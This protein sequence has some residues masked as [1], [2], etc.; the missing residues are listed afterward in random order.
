MVV[1]AAVL[2]IGQRTYSRAQVV[3]ARWEAGSPV[4]LKLVDGTWAKL[5]DL[6]HSSSTVA[7][8]IRAWLNERD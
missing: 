5:P 2:L 1:V 7:G 6:G 3:E 8:A 4:S